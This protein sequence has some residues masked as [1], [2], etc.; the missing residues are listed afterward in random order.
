MRL[1]T[2]LEREP[3]E[4]VNAVGKLD[5]L[6]D[7]CCQTYK[8]DGSPDAHN[9]QTTQLSYPAREGARL[10]LDRDGR[11][12]CAWLAHIVNLLNTLPS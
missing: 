3:R 4:V 12:R 1:D 8:R 7:G 6:P 2:K 10:Q 9:P 5:P 11:I